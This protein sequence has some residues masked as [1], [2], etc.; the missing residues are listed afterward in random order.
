MPGR[1]G[2]GILHFASRK[3]R[4]A[5][6][7]RV[8]KGNPFFSTGCTVRKKGGPLKRLNIYLYIYTHAKNIR[9]WHP[10]K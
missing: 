9:K 5:A 6:K 10:K 8:E 1:L 7:V 3:I 4:K 2:A